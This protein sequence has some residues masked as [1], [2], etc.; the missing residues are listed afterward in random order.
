[1]K[2]IFIKILNFLISLQE[3]INNEIDST[4]NEEYENIIHKLFDKNNFYKK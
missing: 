2:V 4:S 1:M 3:K